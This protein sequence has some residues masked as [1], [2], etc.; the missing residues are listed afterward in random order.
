MPL[1]GA[2]RQSRPQVI[3]EQFRAK[4][5][6]NRGGVRSSGIDLYDDW[7]GRTGR[8]NRC[9]GPLREPPHFKLRV[10]HEDLF[11]FDTRFTRILI[12]RL[13]MGSATSF[14]FAAPREAR[15]R[16]RLCICTTAASN[17]AVQQSG[18]ANQCA[19]DR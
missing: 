8:H 17:T 15:G 18:T 19:A 13:C 2:L 7:R 3:L 14:R 12:D 9:R 1:R 10:S 6:R 11:H 5:D 16:K 4:Y